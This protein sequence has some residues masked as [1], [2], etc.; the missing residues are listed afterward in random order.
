MKSYKEEILKGIEKIKVLAILLEEKSLILDLDLELGDEIKLKNLNLTDESSSYPG[1]KVQ[2]NPEGLP[3]GLYYADDLGKDFL[4]KRLNDLKSIQEDLEKILSKYKKQFNIA[5]E[6][7]VKK[8]YPITK[9][10]IMIN[11]AGGNAGKDSV[12]YRVSLPAE[13]IKNMGI[14]LEDREVELVYENNMITIRKATK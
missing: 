11:K 4:E 3:L 6:N 8:Y 14:T 1:K 5:V 13:W 2:I 10:N 9:R 12:N 7:G